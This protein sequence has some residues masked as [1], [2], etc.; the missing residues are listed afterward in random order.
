MGSYF[1][2]WYGSDASGAGREH[3]VWPKSLSLHR[4]SGRRSWL[5]D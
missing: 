2:F 5:N 4:L 1:G 3:P